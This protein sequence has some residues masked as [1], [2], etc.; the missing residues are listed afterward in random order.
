[1]S[2]EISSCC[3]RVPDRAPGDGGDGGHGTSSKTEARR[4]G[5]IAMAVRGWSPGS[6]MPPLRGGR[7]SDTPRTQA[8]PPLP[9]AWSAGCASIAG[10]CSG[11]WPGRHRSRDHDRQITPPCLC[12][13]V[14]EACSVSSVRSV[15]KPRP[16]LYSD[17]PGRCVLPASCPSSRS[18][19]AGPWAG[20]ADRETGTSG[21]M[22]RPIHA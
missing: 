3:P 22:P 5:R 15:Y 14:F 18:R 17:E 11:Q 4:H 10:P 2:T 8:A 13:S 16:L 20:A 21:S 12:V 7:S 19:S 9:A 6:P 1:M